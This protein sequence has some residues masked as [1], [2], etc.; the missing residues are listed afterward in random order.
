LVQK[1][2]SANKA[3]ASDK[4]KKKRRKKKPI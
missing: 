4:P 3:V 2:S 1:G